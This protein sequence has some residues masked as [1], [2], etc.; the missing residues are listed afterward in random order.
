MRLS[1]RMNLRKLAAGIISTH[2]N[3]AAAR[4][5]LT[6]L[7]WVAQDEE[8]RYL[9]KRYWEANR[10]DRPG[11]IDAFMQASI[12]HS[13]LQVMNYYRKRAELRVQTARNRKISL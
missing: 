2:K 11:N 3:P 13:A 6:W 7:Y 12:F 9:F 1:E 10:Q 5:H 4:E 8:L